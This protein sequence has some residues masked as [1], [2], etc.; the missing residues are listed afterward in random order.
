MKLTGKCKEDFEKWYKNPL[1]H[2]VA[3]YRSI[4]YWETFPDSMQYGVYEDFFDSVYKKNQIS[5][6]VTPNRGFIT[7]SPFN[8]SVGVGSTW[9]NGCDVE[10]RHEARTAAIEKVI[11]IYNEQNK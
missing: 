3:L 2:K 7:E 11:E 8:W 4:K 10:T 5:F 1:R 6:E 9:V